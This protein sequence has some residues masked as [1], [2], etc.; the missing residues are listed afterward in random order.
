MRRLM[1]LDDLYAYYVEQNKSMKFECKEDDEIIVSVQGNLSFA[2][3][4]SPTDGL[5]PVDLRLCFIGDNLNG[6]RIRKESM[7][8]ALPSAKNRPIL[9][10]IHKVDDVDQFYGHNMHLDGEGNVI[11]DEIPLGVITEEARLEYDEDMDREYAVSRGYIYE[12]YTKATEILQREQKCDTSVEI[13]VRSLSYDSDDKIL[14]LDDFYFSGL[15]ILGYDDNG[16]KVKPAMP[17]SNIKIE[18]FSEIDSFDLEDQNFNDINTARKEDNE[19]EENIVEITPNEVVEETEKSVQYSVKIGENVK[20]FSVS[21]SDVLYSLSQL[22]NETYANDGT[23]YSVDAYAENKE[24]IMVDCWNGKAFKQG[25]KVKKD[26]YS[27]VGD[28]VP[29][30]AVYVTADEE[31]KL[32]EMRANYSVFEEKLRKYEEEPQKMEILNSEEYAK[33]SETEEFV[34]LKNDHF[35]MSIEDVHAKADQIILEY[36]KSGKLDFS[37]DKTVTSKQ[38]PYIKKKTGR[39]GNLFNK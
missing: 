16:A 37:V 35:D 10:Y 6:S 36:A 31:A 14:V 23:Y 30:K 17:G 2:K 28:R 39:Y 4:S 7:E 9:G 22:V 32:D 27:L 8:Q 38:L 12:E 5:Y 19:M 26:V 33:V 21:M 20:D 25:Y 24:L 34:A 3:D 18:G 13:A 29:V 15:T 1:T 11:Y